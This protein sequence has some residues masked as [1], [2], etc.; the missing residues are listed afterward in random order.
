MDDLQMSMLA[1][2]DLKPTQ[3]S[4][5]MELIEQNID[6]AF[7]ESDQEKDEDGYIPTEVIE[8]DGEDLVVEGEKEEGPASADDEEEPEEPQEEEEEVEDDEPTDDSPTDEEEPEVEDLDE[9]E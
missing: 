2:P 3:I 4:E 5:A 6:A 7:E 9:Y 8:S 1:D